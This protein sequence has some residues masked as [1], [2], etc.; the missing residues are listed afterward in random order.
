MQ[1]D[2]I[3][4]YDIC[5]WLQDCLKLHITRENPKIF[6]EHEEK[7]LDNLGLL[8]VYMYYESL[9]NKYA[10]DSEKLD[11]RYLNRAIN[12]RFRLLANQLKSK[13]QTE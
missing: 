8:K 11:A 5:I 12:R 1:C 9:I 4:L 3:Q 2:G 13:N 7:I 10:G 6:M